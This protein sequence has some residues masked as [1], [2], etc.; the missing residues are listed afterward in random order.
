MNIEQCYSEI[1]GNY[2][3]VIKR[4]RSDDRIIKYLK[5]FLKDE[6]FSRLCD[7]MESKEYQE[8]FREVHTLKGLCQNMAFSDLFVSA[9]ELTE[10]LRG[11]EY[12]ER[13]IEIFEEL[14]IKY[15]TVRKCIEG[16]D[17]GE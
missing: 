6:T 15:S 3:D 1:G 13:A 12:G 5:M 16:M 4:L 8:A 17:N 7:A 14:K 11:G 2:N 10:C 9:N